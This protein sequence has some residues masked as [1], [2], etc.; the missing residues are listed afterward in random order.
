MSVGLARFD[1][2]DIGG[3]GV[4]LL[5]TIFCCTFPPI[6]DFSFRFGAGTLV[7]AGFSES[8]ILQ[9]VH[10]GVNAEYGTESSSEQVSERSPCFSCALKTL[11]TELTGSSSSDAVS[12][13]KL[14]T[15]ARDVGNFHWRS[16]VCWILDFREYLH[17][18]TAFK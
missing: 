5:V 3:V 8:G 1:G 9:L 18:G 12:D 10:S 6:T 13:C 16:E 17:G 7:V 15:I 14:R 4:S 11:P 2:G